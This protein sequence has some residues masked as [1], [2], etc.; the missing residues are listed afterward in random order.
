MI[1]ATVNGFKGSEFKKNK[2]IFLWLTF[3]RKNSEHIYVNVFAH[4]TREEARTNR[5]FKVNK[6]AE[7]I[8]GLPKSE[9]KI[10]T[11]GI[12]GNG[13]DAV[14]LSIHNAV[15]AKIQ[16]FGLTN[17]VNLEVV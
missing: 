9:F 14:E 6:E 17:I 8:L 7:M 3:D 1:K 11:A 2:S 16:E 13:F 15:M 10:D 5:Y 4:K 12:T